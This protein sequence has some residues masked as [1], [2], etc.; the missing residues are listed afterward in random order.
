MLN[1]GYRHSPEPVDLSSPR[2]CKIKRAL[3][4]VS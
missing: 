4:S 3:A 1:K 2:R